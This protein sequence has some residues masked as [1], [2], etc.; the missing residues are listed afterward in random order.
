MRHKIK[1]TPPQSKKVYSTVLFADISG[2]TPLTEKLSKRGDEGTYLEKP[3]FVENN[4]E[5]RRGDFDGSSKRIFRQNDRFHSRAQWRH[6][7]ICGRRPVGLVA[8][9]RR[10]E[11]QSRRC[12]NNVIMTYFVFLAEAG[13]D[14]TVAQASKCALSMQR[15]LTGYNVAGCSLTL[16]IG[17]GAG[18]KIS[19]GTRRGKLL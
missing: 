8:I 15:N 9:L 2:F 7:K 5:I 6:C 14:Y 19:L 1:L 17:I 10:Y 18:A 16:H 4:R 12:L 11:R 3:V 13:L